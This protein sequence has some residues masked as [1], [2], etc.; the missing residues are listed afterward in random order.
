V[1]KN[2]LNILNKKLETYSE[3]FI[4]EAQNNFWRN[5]LC[6]D[7]VFCLKLLTQE[8]REYNLEAHLLFLDY[9][10]AFDSSLLYTDTHTIWHTER[11][12]YPE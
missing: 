10:K 9:E 5:R 3:Q 8:R 12:Q 4:C 7:S 6:S 11:Q 1:L 2:I